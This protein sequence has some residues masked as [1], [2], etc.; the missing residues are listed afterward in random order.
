MDYASRY[1]LTR[2]R[3][4]TL[5]RSL[6]DSQAASPVPGCPAWTVKDVYAHLAGIIDDVSNGRLEDITTDPW[7][8][9]QVEERAAMTFA[10]VL[11]EWESYDT[12]L[13]AVASSAQE[14]GQPNLLIDLWTHGQDIRGAVGAPAEGDDDFT[15][16]CAE[17]LAPV[18]VR[19]AAKAGLPPV[20]LRLGAAVHRAS[21]D[22]AVVLSVE[23]FEY[24][25]GS[26]GRRSRAQMRAWDWA[27]SGPEGDP[28]R[29]IDCLTI[30][31]IAESDIVESI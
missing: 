10:E 30:F 1:R 2:D 5:G 21:D 16:W 3:L 19:R 13:D 23:P 24:V 22:P 18:L 14:L 28:D 4:L 8:Q 15:I 29:Y 7:T 20:E 31:G 12:E 17:Q 25:R 6:D 26:M 11:D 9:R 27:W